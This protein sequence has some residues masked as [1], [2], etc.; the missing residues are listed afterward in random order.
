MRLKAKT[1]PKNAGE[2]KRC[3]AVFGQMVFFYRRPCDRIKYAVRDNFL[4]TGL[5]EEQREQVFS[6]MQRLDVSRGQVVIRIGE[7]GDFFYVV[8]RGSFNVFKEDESGEPL[9]RYSPGGSFGELALMYNSPRAATVIAVSD[10]SLWRLDRAT[11]RNLLVR[12]C[13][14]KA[15]HVAGLKQ[16]F[17]A[18]ITRQN[19]VQPL[20]A[21]SACNRLYGQHTDSSSRRGGRRHNDVNDNPAYLAFKD[22]VMRMPQTPSAAWAPG[23]PTK[24]FAHT[25]KV[26]RAAPDSLLRG[27]RGKL[28]IVSHATSGVLSQKHNPTRTDRGRI[29]NASGGFYAT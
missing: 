20:D 12:N 18:V 13:N 9:Y 3:V 7:L 28:R 17:K 24:R 6:S 22:E 27:S 11:F 16:K 19:A 8:D 2:L 1:Y 25:C 10:A 14:S 21:A 15:S 26:L 4:F 5:N 23:S 29:R